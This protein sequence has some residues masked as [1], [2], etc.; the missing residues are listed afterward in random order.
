MRKLMIAFVFLLLCVI[1]T[2]TQYDFCD[3]TVLVFLEPTYSSYTCNL[4]PKFWGNL[5]FESVEHIT[6]ITNQA[7]IDVI[8]ATTI[9]FQSIYLITLPSEDHSLVLDTIK[10]LKKI[11]GVAD[12]TPNHYLEVE[13]APNDEYWD[14]PGSWYLKGPEGKKMNKNSFFYEVYS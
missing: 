8:E 5:K 10:E 9:P 11:P 1:I 4:N 3:H 7:A 13:S 12:A 2:G 14:H 6:E